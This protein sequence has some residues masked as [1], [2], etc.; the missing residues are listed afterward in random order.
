MFFE[1]IS[2]QKPLKDIKSLSTRL[3]RQ[4]TLVCQGIGPLISRVARMAFDPAPLNAVSALRHHLVQNLPK[5]RI[6]DSLLGGG[7]PS[8]RFPTGQPFRDAFA[9][10]LAV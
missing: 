5:I 10:I 2:D 1:A 6:F 8:P 7:T 9:N 4:N 3:N